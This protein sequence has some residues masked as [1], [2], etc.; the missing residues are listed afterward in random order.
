M[1]DKSNQLV[2]KFVTRLYYMH[3]KTGTQ[4]GIED[5]TFVFFPF[6]IYS[7]NCELVLISFCQFV[8]VIAV[9]K[10]V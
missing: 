6:S 9:I 8:I 4:S 3:I 5:M 1:N 10:N 2:T 7:R